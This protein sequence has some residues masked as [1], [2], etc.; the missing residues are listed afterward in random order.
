MYC[1]IKLRI[2]LLVYVDDVDCYELVHC[3]LIGQDR[4]K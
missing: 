4:F 1:I 2:L 3:S